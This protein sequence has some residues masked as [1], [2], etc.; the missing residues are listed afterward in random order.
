MDDCKITKVSRKPMNCPICK[1]KVVEILYGEPTEFAMQ[2]V[3]EKKWVLGGCCITEGIPKWEC[4]E[5]KKR[6]LTE[7][8]NP[9]LS[10]K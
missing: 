4:V 9:K 8:C 6:F 3:Q 7:N 1:V 5:S 10:N 2:L